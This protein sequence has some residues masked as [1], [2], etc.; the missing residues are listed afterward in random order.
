MSG[1]VPRGRRVGFAATTVALALIVVLAAAEVALR[2][3]YGKIERI[4]GA[5][6]W[7]VARSDGL[8]Y[9]WDEYHPRLG[10][11]NRAGY[12]SD[13]RVPFAVTI[14]GQ[15]LRGPRDYAARP[16]EGVRRL[17]VFGDSMTFGEEVDDDG[18]LPAHLERQL[19]DNE[20]LNFG[21]HGYGLGQ[22]ALR[23]EHE[24]FAMN[25]DHVV[26][27]LL[28][29]ADIYRDPQDHFVHN[30]PV[31]RLVDWELQISNVPVPVEDR[32]PW[33]LRR[34]FAAAWFLD[35]PERGPD[36]GTD[37]VVYAELAKQL[38]YRIKQGCDAQGVPFTLALIVDAAT[39]R[40]S[41]NERTARDILNQIRRT[42]A[43]PQVG[44]ID[45]LDLTDRLREA[46]AREGP[47]LVA[48][49]GH[50]SARGNCRIAA[51]IAEHLAATDPAWSLST[52]RAS[53]DGS[54]SSAEATGRAG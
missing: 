43:G 40:Q 22:M 50:W 54:S 18:T 9:H 7:E 15:G 27:V 20:A 30:K 33:L 2:V 14:N 51:W 12:R 32:Q 11:T 35:R 49:H 45:T 47:S 31:F 28:L 10:W 21:V 24:G 17:A 23:L 39:L 25:P 41:A 5:S 38:V 29:P 1:A 26:V 34:S 46:H 13:D 37:L 3:R 42:L 16:P 52:D 8:T 48:A 44:G 36:P 4:T 6:E 53:C 19:A